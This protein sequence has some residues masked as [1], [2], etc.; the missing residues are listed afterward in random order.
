[1]LV[2][3]TAILM[4]Q[5]SKVPC[6]LVESFWLFSLF[7]VLENWL[8]RVAGCSSGGCTCQSGYAGKNRSMG[9][10]WLVFSGGG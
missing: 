2:L 9:I 5:D 4:A 8:A 10:C 1:M 3:I 6:G 7:R